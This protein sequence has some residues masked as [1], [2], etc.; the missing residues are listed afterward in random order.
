MSFPS[1]YMAV[2]YFVLLGLTSCQLWE[3]IGNW[4]SSLKKKARN[5]VHEHYQWDPQNRQRFVALLMLTS[6]KRFWS[7]ELS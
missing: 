5:C 7:V 6:Q 2:H 1:W 4:W 3:D